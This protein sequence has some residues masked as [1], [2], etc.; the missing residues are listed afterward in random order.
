[1]S[2]CQVPRRDPSGCG[3]R[4]PT[5]WPALTASDSRRRGSSPTPSRRCG[6]LGTVPGVAGRWGIVGLP[7]AGPSTTVATQAPPEHAVDRVNT[8]AEVVLHLAVAGLVPAFLGGVRRHLVAPVPGQR[9][10]VRRGGDTIPAAQIVAAATSVAPPTWRLM[11]PRTSLRVISVTVKNLTC[12]I[13]PT[14]AG[15]D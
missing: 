11:T 12:H 2:V 8:R 14:R 1:M 15:H 10:T 4:T 6:P 9:L 7:G 5:R 3:C 13:C